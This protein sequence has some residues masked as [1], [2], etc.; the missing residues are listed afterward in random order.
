[1]ELHHHQAQETED[2]AAVDQVIQ[3]FL[4]QEIHHQQV[5]HKETQEDQE[6][7]QMAAEAAEELQTQEDQDYQVTIELVE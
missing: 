3:V 1:M 5:H 4:E 2:L 7:E 6:Q